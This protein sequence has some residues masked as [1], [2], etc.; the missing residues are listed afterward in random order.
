VDPTTQRSARVSSRP[1]GNAISRWPQIAGNSASSEMPIVNSRS[2]SDALRLVANQAKPAA[3]M[4]RPVAFAGRRHQ[5]NRPVPM[6]DQPTSSR[7]TVS[8]SG[9]SM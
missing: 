8:D 6:N 1:L 4:S 3:T 9:S 7:S 5:A 2:L